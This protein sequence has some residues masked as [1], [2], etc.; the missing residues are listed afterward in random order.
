MNNIFIHRRYAIDQGIARKL[1]ADPKAAAIKFQAQRSSEIFAIWH[2]AF[3]KE[4]NRVIRTM[5]GWAANKRLTSQ[6]L[7]WQQM[8]KQVDAFAIAPYFY[9]D[10]KTLRKAKH[11][12]DVFTAMQNKRSRYGLPASIEQ[13]NEQ[14]K[15]AKSF[16]VHLIAYEGGQH[17]VDWETRKLEQHP[18]PLLL[19]ANRD[20]RMAELYQDYLAAWQQADAGVFVHFSAPRIPG[21][22]GV[23]GAKEYI[24]QPRSQAPKYDALLRF[25]GK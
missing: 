8:Y 13:I 6:L 21:W 18:N 9:A 22:Y 7:S 25:L 14:A 1:D 11:V 10:L 20:P 19:Q 2:T 23:W 17:L 16:G 4:K 3:G 15:M 24:T 12:D 5:A